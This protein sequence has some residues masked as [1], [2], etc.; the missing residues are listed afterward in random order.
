MVADVLFSEFFVEVPKQ[1]TNYG[2][3]DWTFF[4][5]LIQN[6]WFH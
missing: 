5:K 4:L 2:L 3:T 1:P 6:Y